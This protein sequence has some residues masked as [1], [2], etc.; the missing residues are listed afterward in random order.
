MIKKEWEERTYHELRNQLEK[1][2]AA[3]LIDLKQ[4]AIDV[5]IDKRKEF[6][7]SLLRLARGIADADKRN[8]VYEVLV[9]LQSTWTQYRPEKRLQAKFRA[10]FDAGNYREAEEV[11]KRLARQGLDYIDTFQA[12]AGRLMPIYA[13]EKNMLLH[14]NK[15]EIT[16]Y[17]LGFKQLTKL[18]VPGALEIIDVIAP[19][20]DEEIDDIE[21][22]EIKKP[23]HE[24]WL[25]MEEKNNKKII[26]SLDIANIDA[27]ETIE[28][29]LEHG[30]VELDQEM[31][32]VNRLA[33][34]QDHLLLV[35]NRK[36]YYRRDDNNWL[37]WYT[38]GNKITAIK[39]TK[40][41][42]WVGHLNGNVFML[43]DWQHVGN[44]VV[45]HGF[46]EEI[47]NICSTGRYVYLW[48]EK[49]LI[50]ADQGCKQISEPV[51]THCRI[52]QADIL[53]EYLL[54][55]TANGMLTSRDIFQ[56][57]LCWQI[58]LGDIYDI[59]F[60]YRHYLFCGRRDG[61]TM[62]FEI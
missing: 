37:E 1:D 51:V 35:S 19:I 57:N 27:L 55:F 62:V 39:T 34:F 11:Y 22:G 29:R 15:K 12:G 9:S 10:A 14:Y 41:G 42:C 28:H 2:Q 54:L 20:T 31:L 45:L 44:R 38:T 43:K 21:I 30:A 24:I 3:L 48:S 16:F 23:G 36:I 56:G 17:D 5:E 6:E 49:R 60:S 25:L 50:I 58:N 53:E 46:S 47:E 13:G 8:A 52:V 26:V 59:L 32:D 61:E 7:N 18:F 4:R 40:E 33:Y